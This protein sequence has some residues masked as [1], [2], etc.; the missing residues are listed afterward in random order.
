MPCAPHRL[1]DGEKKRVALASVLS[2]D[3]DVWLMDEP[4]AGPDPRSR[5]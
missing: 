4:T 1:A 3:P 5:S 2:L